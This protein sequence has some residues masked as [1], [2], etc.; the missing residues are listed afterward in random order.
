MST[1]IK[2]IAVPILAIGLLTATDA[3][4]AEAQ[5][6]SFGS[7]GLSIQI[8]QRYPSYYSRVPSCYSPSYNSYR[9]PYRSPI[10]HNYG[11][12]G[13]HP[14]EIYRHRNHYDVIPGHFDYHVQP[15]CRYGRRY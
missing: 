14:T 7:R 15:H 9:Y 6:F 4:Q 8:G 10:R 11:H 5:G 2:W 3:P 13:Y 12:Y 1:P